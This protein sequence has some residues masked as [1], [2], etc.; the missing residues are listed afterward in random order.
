MHLARA[1][2]LA[3]VA[4]C[5]SGTSVL[6][7]PVGKSFKDWEV[8]CDNAGDCIAIGYQAYAD[9]KSGQY[10]QLSIKAGGAAKPELTFSAEDMTEEDASLVDAPPELVGKPLVEQFLGIARKADAVTFAVG[11]KRTVF[12]LVGLSASLLAIDEVQ[13]RIGTATAFVRP[14]PKPASA[15]PPA[16]ALPRVKPVT[17]S[18]LNGADEKLIAALA[19]RVKATDGKEC[20]RI[21]EAG[22]GEIWRLSARLSLVELYCESFAYN[23]TSRFWIVEGANI[24]TAKPVVFQ[25][26]TERPDTTLMNAEYDPGSG[27]ISY[28]GKGRGV[29]DCGQSGSYAWTGKAFVLQAQNQLLACN[30]LDIE[31]PAVWRTAQ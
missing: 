2:V 10:I 1:L 21:A 30:G 24:A 8:A 22:S 7:A 26:A 9:R 5:L 15:V 11:D 25:R 6:S 4:A 18:N 19:R 29:G 31:W 14:G 23:F 12:S 3:G 28:M 13:G 16:K 17:T 27:V 20:P